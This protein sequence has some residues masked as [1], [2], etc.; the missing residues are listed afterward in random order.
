MR[1]LGS[2]S[3]WPSRGWLGSRR[4]PRSS[5]HIPVLGEE[6]V[7]HSQRGLQVTVDN[8]CGETKLISGLHGPHALKLAVMVPCHLP[9]ILICPGWSSDATRGHHGQVGVEGQVGT[10]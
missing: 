6:V 10:Q 3:R 5:L 4:Q 2:W 8:V 1:Q 9:L 7:Q